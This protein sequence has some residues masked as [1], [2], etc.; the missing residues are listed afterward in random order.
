MLNGAD[1]DIHKMRVLMMSTE[2]LLTAVILM[3][4]GMRWCWF[5]PSLDRRVVPVMY[6]WYLV[7]AIGL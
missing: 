2:L 3:L 1:L 4:T 5:N 7:F 6:N